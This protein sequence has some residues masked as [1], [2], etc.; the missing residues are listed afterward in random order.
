MEPIIIIYVG[1][2]SVL[3][4]FATNILSKNCSDNSKKVNINKKK[5]KHYHSH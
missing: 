1:C 4:L 3:G 5:F 2:M